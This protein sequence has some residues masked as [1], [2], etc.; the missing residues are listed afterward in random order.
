MQNHLRRHQT[1]AVLLLLLGIII[2]ISSGIFLGHLE[3]DFLY[4][5]QRDQKTMEAL[6]STK[7]A[8]IGW[9]VGHPN[10]PGL[11][12]WT[13]RKGDGNYDGDSDCASLASDAAFNPV[14][15][16]GRIPWRGR[17]NP[18]ERVHGGLG[19]NARDGAGERLWY[20]VSRNLIRRYQ[21]PAGYPIIN[22]ALVNTAPFPWLTVRDAANVVIS[23]RVAAVIL[24]SGSALS[25]QD[26]SVDAPNAEN[27]LD[28]HVPTGIDNADADDCFDANPDCGGTDG[29]DF[30]LADAN[31]SFNDRLVFITVDELMG[32]VEERVLN[33]ADK[34]LDDYL[35]TADP[36]TASVYPWPSPFAYPTAVL[37]GNVTENGMDT[38]RD[39]IDIHADFIA[40]GI[41]PGQVI[42]NVTDGS[43]GIIN[44]VD[45]G[46]MLTLTADGLRGG[47]DNRFDINRISVPDD[48]DSYEIL[49][50]TSGLAT[51]GSLGDIL[52]DADRLAESGADFGTLGVQVG[53]IVENVSDETYGVV[54][55][56]P[57]PDTMV[58]NRLGADG[59]VD[60]TMAFD[61][62]DSYEIPR[63]NGIPGTWAGALPFHVMGERF[64]TGFTVA[65]NIPEEIPDK[66]S[67]ADNAGYLASIENAIRCSDDINQMAADSVADPPATNGCNPDSSPKEIPWANGSCAWAGLDTVRCEGKTNW[68]WYLAGTITG[69]HE[70]A[71]L[72]FEDQDADF[73]ALGVETGDVVLNLTDGAHGVIREVTAQ[74]IVAFGLYGGVENQFDRDDEYRI[75]VATGIIPETG[76]ACAEVWDGADTITCGPDTL[77]DI[78]ADFWENGVRPGDTIENRT[79]GWWRIIEDV[80]RLGAFSN[81]QDTLRM[82][83]LPGADGAE[84]H[85]ADGDSYTIRTGFV[86]KRRYVFNLAFTGHVDLN[87]KPGFRSVG[88]D[89]NA[90]LPLPNEIRIQD[91]DIL[92]QRTV[93]DVAMTTY[94]TTMGEIRVSG[95]GRDLSPDF[96]AWFLANHWHHFIYMAV[97]R[98]HFPEGSGQC[99]PGDDCLLLN[100]KN[101]GGNTARND[102]TALLIAAGRET[103]GAQCIQNRPASDSAQYFEEENAL[104]F[105]NAGA[106]ISNPVFKKRHSR[107]MDA[108]FQDRVHVV[109]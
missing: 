12:P 10:A 22:P 44:S 4:R 35:T 96:P 75:R 51:D 3:Q 67:L 14:F 21:S 46:T 95:I 42:R 9:A 11:M 45:N 70:N 101:T 49:T 8:L 60:G 65:W 30:V 102:V 23:E 50:D 89:I 100:T 86:D 28:I 13:D 43:K 83:A 36:T 1:G 98:G 55:A 20:A 74:G 107:L 97:A 108:C 2:L 66:M 27:Y 29:E 63:F 92:N 41:R 103:D 16:L 24:A 47:Q 53:D 71:A 15:L 64:R 58:L 87:D 25:G 88:T 109:E 40:A 54:V 32:A 93:V 6:F 69:T 56:L 19:I 26:R 85:F 99:I 31:A 5:S 61:P 91:R 68:G 52:Q 80:G 77:V 33:D 57:A 76:A 59:T 104:P 90:L 17:T 37:S 73:R 82:A 34:I 72:G 84:N 39:L 78:D 18:C 94:P 105:T 62:G 106:D 81:T 38:S 79:K 48:N 7:Q